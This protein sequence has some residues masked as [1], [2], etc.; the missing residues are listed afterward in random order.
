MGKKVINLKD[1]IKN[2]SRTLDFKKVN[3]EIES[4]NLDEY[5]DELASKLKNSIHN[6]TTRSKNKKNN[7]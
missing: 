7:D 5:L 4:Y 2:K 3:D 1:Y 6:A